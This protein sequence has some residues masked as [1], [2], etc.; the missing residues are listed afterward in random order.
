MS[1]SRAASKAGVAIA[2]AVGAGRVARGAVGVTG[3]DRADGGRWAPRPARLP[4]ARRGPGEVDAEVDADV[5]A[6]EPLLVAGLAGGVT[7]AGVSRRTTDPGPV[8]GPAIDTPRRWTVE[9]RPR[10]DG[11]RAGWR[12]AMAAWRRA[13]SASKAASPVRWTAGDPSGATISVRAPAQ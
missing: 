3:S 10:G 2:P 12:L 5:E 6:S 8:S 9:G 13:R 11:A 1:A 7:G 4:R